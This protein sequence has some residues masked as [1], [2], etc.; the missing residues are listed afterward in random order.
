[1]MGTDEIQNHNLAI[2]RL[3]LFRGLDDHMGA[4]VAKLLRCA[5][6]SAALLSGIEILT[7]LTT[8]YARCTIQLPIQLPPLSNPASVMLST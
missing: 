5:V 4:V 2:R 8:F 6:H 7:T 1:M 3:G